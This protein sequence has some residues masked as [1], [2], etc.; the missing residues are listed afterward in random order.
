MLE[1]KW[2]IIKELIPITNFLC[3]PVVKI[4]I[5]IFLACDKTTSS[6]V[7]SLSIFAIVISKAFNM[8][9]L[10][11]ILV[12]YV[13]MYSETYLNFLSKFKTCYVPL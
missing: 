3:K 1:N 5:L 2:K 6:P 9:Q 7:Y 8:I 10:M 11:N 12:I 4:Y 13:Y